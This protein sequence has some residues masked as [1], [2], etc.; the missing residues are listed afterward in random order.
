MEKVNHLNV[1]VATGILVILFEKIDA[2]LFET[3]GNYYIIINN[4]E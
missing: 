1:A 2:N 4:I 3:H